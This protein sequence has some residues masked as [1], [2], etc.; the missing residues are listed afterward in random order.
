ML[1]PQCLERYLSANGIQ[2][3]MNIVVLAL[4]GIQT[5][6]C[7]RLLSRHTVVAKEHVIISIRTKAAIS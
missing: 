3:L 5:I 6:N 4:E 1:S 2:T 7:G